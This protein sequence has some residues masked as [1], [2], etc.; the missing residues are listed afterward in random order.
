MSV[1]ERVQAINKQIAALREERD[2]ILFPFE[3][4]FEETNRKVVHQVLN[5]MESAFGTAHTDS[6]LAERLVAGLTS[7]GIELTYDM[8]EKNP[9]EPAW[10]ITTCAYKWGE[11]CIE[12]EKYWHIHHPSTYRLRCGHTDSYFTKNPLPIKSWGDLDT[13]GDMY[14]IAAIKMYLADAR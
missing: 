13:I 8:M 7:Y 4:T 2:A 12:F 6:I 14:K 3:E 11:M 10:H 9:Y 1:S 5:Y